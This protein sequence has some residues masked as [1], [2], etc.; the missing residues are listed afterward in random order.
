MRE[1]PGGYETIDDLERLADAGD[2]HVMAGL[3]MVR[4]RDGDGAG[5]EAL[6]RRAADG[7]YAFAL[8][9]LAEMR[10][11]AGDVTS[12]GDLYREAA[13]AGQRSRYLAR[14]L[15]YGLDPDG[16]PTPAWS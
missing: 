5:A 9:G 16:S 2:P 10:E 6:V 11:E 3:A 7:G 4:E 15:P 1:K 13:D 14:T 8:A 12:A